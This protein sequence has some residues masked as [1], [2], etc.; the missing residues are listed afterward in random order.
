MPSTHDEN[1]IPTFR[2]DGYL[3][4]GLYPATLAEITFRFGTSADAGAF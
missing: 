3:P 1:S 4:E 2:P